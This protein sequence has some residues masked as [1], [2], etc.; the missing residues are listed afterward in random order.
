[1]VD[2][3]NEVIMYIVVGLLTFCIEI[4]VFVLL[5]IIGVSANL[6][7]IISFTLPFFF[8]YIAHCLLTFKTTPTFASVFRYGIV[9]LLNA[10][11]HT[12]VF[13]IGMHLLGLP[14]NS[15]KLAAMLLSSVL[16]FFMQKHFTYDFDQQ[17]N[18][19]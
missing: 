12:A 4:G 6:S 7:A 15:A 17:R 9:L 13:W 19:V 5:R 2:S 1:M 18:R 8:N 10:V 14:P 11:T 16:I 3:K